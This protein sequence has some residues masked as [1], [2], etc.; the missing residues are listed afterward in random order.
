MFGNG[1]AVYL[2]SVAA[3]QV[4]NFEGISFE[5]EDAVMSR[6]SWVTNGDL[7]GAIPPKRYF[8][9]REFDDLILQGASDDAQSGSHN[10][11]NKGNLL[12]NT[13]RGFLTECFVCWGL[14]TIRMDSPSRL[15]SYFWSSWTRF[16]LRDSRPKILLTH[17]L[18][19][20]CVILIHF[21][22]DRIPF[23]QEDAAKNG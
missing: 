13:A 1:G 5:C 9:R 23:G 12:F 15:D 22:R 20:A 6:Q 21:P 16:T 17:Y 14:W 4:A 8:A 10:V 3:P 11:E 2:G 19:A 7:I 18:S